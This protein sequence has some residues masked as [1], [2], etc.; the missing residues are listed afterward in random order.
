MGFL[1]KLFMIDKRALHKIERKTKPVFG[2]EEEYRALKDS[3]LKAKTVEFKKRLAAGETVDDLLPE[4][5]AAAREGARR[6]IGQFPYPCQVFGAAVL[7]EGDVAEMKTGEGKTLTATMAVYLNALEG[8]GAHV[9]TVNEYLAGRDADWMGRIYRFL[10]LTCGFNSHEKNTQQKQEAYNCDI[11]YTTNSELGFDYLR[12]NMATSVANRVL[13]RNGLHFAIVDEADSILIDESRTPLIISGGSGITASSYEAADRAVKSLRP[14]TDF[15]IDVKKKLATLTD[16]GINKIQSEFGIANLFEP[17]YADLT[18]RIQQA[19]KANYA[20]KR[21]IEYMVADG[22]ILL[23]DSFTG[24][25]MK[26]RE[27]SDGLQQALEAKEHV[28]IKPETITMATITYQNFFRLYDKLSGMTGTAKTEE[29][30]FRKIYNMRVIPIPTNRPIQ[31]FDDT[32]SVFGSEQAKFNA[33]IADIKDRHAH[34][35]PILVGTPSV[36]QSEI[37][38]KMLNAAKIPH[39]VLNAKNHAREAAIIAQAGQ[40]GAVTVATNMAGRGTDIKLGRGVKDICSGN[41][42]KQHHYNGLAVLGTER[43]ESRRVDNQL[44]G[45]SGRQ[46]DPGYSKFYVAVQ[47]ELLKR[48]SSDTMTKMFAGLGPDAVDSPMLTRAITSAQKKVEGQ[49]FDTRKSLLDYDDILRQQREKMYAKRDKILYSDSIS[50]TLPEYFRLAAKAFVEQ[51]MV[52]VDQ[53]RVVDADKLRTLVEARDIQKGKFNST[54][55]KGLTEEEG[56][57]FLTTLLLGLYGKHKADWSKE[58]ENYAEK[59][60][61]MTCIDRSW[62]KH[63]DTMAKLRD[64]IWLRS[65]ANTDPLQAYAH[66]GFE[67]FDKM[68]ATIADEI[69]YRLLNVTFRSRPMDKRQAVEAS[70]EEKA[71]AAEALAK[72]QEAMKATQYR[73]NESKGTP[74]KTVKLAPNEGVA[75]SETIAATAKSVKAAI[76]S[77]RP[78]ARD[79]EIQAMGYLRKG[80]SPSQVVNALIK[81]MECG[82][83][84]KQELSLLTMGMVPGFTDTESIVLK[85]RLDKSDVPASGQKPFESQAAF[86]QLM[87][88][89]LGTPAAQANSNN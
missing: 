74:L 87:A 53:E 56:I 57:E 22:E 86:Q 26:G 11:T 5:F 21:D 35:Q 68:Q 42:E 81:V 38:D 36:E 88:S 46:G 27:Y 52:T 58:Q 80:Y 61:A 45:R 31:R 78:T 47:D 25:V 83:L 29:E 63:I 12:D 1:E 62:T 9:V 71:A 2:Y 20:M 49:N 7:N 66:E 37:V 77:Y 32:D 60:I 82:Y 64:A 72:R 70:P 13:R 67:L 59:V 4:A 28:E 30:E 41:V 6:A 44:R 54:P 17:K 55:F 34:G 50:D 85:Q 40:M 23:I 69:V 3:D 16:A 65:Y 10:G 79:I 15:T 39:D 73:L 76:Q 14:N 8:K 18:H 75:S 33:L 24:R 43:N 51:S 84:G 48:F 89:Y 19:L